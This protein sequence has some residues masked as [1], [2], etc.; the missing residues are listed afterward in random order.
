MFHKVA[1]QTVGLDA[2]SAASRTDVIIIA[3][4]ATLLLTGLQWLALRPVEKEAVN[5][6]WPPDIWYEMLLYF[7]SVGI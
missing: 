2:S 6:S 1:V 4:S 3:M 7:C 5:L